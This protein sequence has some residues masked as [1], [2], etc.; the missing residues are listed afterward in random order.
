VDIIYIK[1][2]LY[3]KHADLVLGLEVY[4]DRLYEAKAFRSVLIADS[5]EV[6]TAQNSA[7]RAIS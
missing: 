3:E 1:K 4:L 2:D 7:P 5:G 6:V